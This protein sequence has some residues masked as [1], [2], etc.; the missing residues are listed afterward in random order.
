MCYDA[1]H[2]SGYSLRTED[3]RF[4]LVCV[5]VCVCVSV[6]L[7]VQARVSVRGLFALPPVD[8]DCNELVTVIGPR[9]TAPVT[10]SGPWFVSVSHSRRASQQS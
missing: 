5:C 9:L 4:C 7:S 1:F 8:F 10:V 3:Y 2:I 6:R